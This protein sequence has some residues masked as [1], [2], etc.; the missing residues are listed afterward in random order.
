MWPFT[1]E[2]LVVPQPEDCLPGRTEPMPLPEREGGER[3]LHCWDQLI[4]MQ[5]TSYAFLIQMKHGRRQPLRSRLSANAQRSQSSL[6]SE[7]SDYPP[8]RH[9]AGRR[10]RIPSAE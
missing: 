7:R 4:P 5:Q 1:R 9:C 8:D 2:K 3:V 10:R 6:A